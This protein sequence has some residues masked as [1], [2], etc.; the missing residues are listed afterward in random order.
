MPKLDLLFAISPTSTDA[1]NTLQLMTSAIDSLVHK[2]DSSNIRYGLLVYGDDATIVF[3]LKNNSYADKI[4]EQL[5]ALT[6][7]VGQSALD[8]ALETAT[9]MFAEAGDRSDTDRALVIMTD[10]SSLLSEDI[11][12]DATKPLEQMA[13]K[14]IPVAVGDEV[15][16]T[17]FKIITVKENVIAAAKDEN[18]DDLGEEIME[19]VISK[20]TL[21][22]CLERYLTERRRTQTK[23]ISLANQN[24]RK[25]R[26]GPIRIGIQA[27]GAKRGKRRA[28]AS[29]DW[30]L[31]AS[32]WLRRV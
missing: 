19:R 20:Y 29:D 11:A 14:I 24:K 5:T 27:S 21:K 1:D 2:Y 12:I 7:L 17:E 9:K 4:K 25:Q 13:V 32:H 31:F 16:P 3:D 10:K 22:F 26:N 18:P 30:F 15:N 28:T 23:V 8:K 6:P